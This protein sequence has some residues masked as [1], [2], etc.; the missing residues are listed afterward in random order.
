MSYGT[1]GNKHHA[2]RVF[3]TAGADLN[4]APLSGAQLPGA[5]CNAE[6]Q[7]DPDVN[8]TDAGAALA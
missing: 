1:W 2:Q 7:W 6:T 3:L 8:P 5:R 4:V